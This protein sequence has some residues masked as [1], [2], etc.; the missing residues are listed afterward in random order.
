[1]HQVDS[2][3]TCSALLQTEVELSSTATN[4]QVLL[5]ESIHALRVEIP[6]SLAVEVDTLKDLGDV[7]GV[8]EGVGVCG[9][10]GCCPSAVL[11]ASIQHCTSGSIPQSGDSI[12]HWKVEWCGWQEVTGTSPSPLRVWNQ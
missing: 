2:S 10:E 5:Q 3:A 12:D 9:G 7:A 1:M 6:H 8:E 11:D 4:G